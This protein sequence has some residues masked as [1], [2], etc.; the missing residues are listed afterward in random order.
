MKDRAYPADSAQLE[1]LEELLSTAEDIGYPTKCP[2]YGTLEVTVSDGR[3]LGVTPA[4]DSCSAFMIGDVCYEYGNQFAYDDEGSYDNS[5][6]LAVFGLTPASLEEFIT[7]N[8]PSTEGE[9]LGTMADIGD[10]VR[11]Q[12]DVMEPTYLS[13]EAREVMNDLLGRGLG[14]V[15]GR[16]EITFDTTYYTILS[17]EL[18]TEENMVTLSDNGSL[19]IDGLRYDMTNANALLQLLDAQYAIRIAHDGKVI[20][21]DRYGAVGD[22]LYL[23]LLGVTEE[24]KV[25]WSSSDEAVCT[26]QGDAYGAIVTFNGVGEAQIAAEWKS[27]WNTKGYTFIVHCE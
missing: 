6:L 11:V 5:G 2:F 19:Y 12:N 13:D 24:G 22:D 20:E 16:E 9:V 23:E 18:N 17:S 8:I 25:I 21:S 10:V 7:S 15:I 4:M 27:P 1:F 3:V 14:N 26:V